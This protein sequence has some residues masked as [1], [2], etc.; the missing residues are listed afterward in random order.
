MPKTEHCGLWM[1]MGAVKTT[2]G[3]NTPNLGGQTIRHI[4]MDGT[5][6]TFLKLDP[7][8]NW[9][10]NDVAV[11]KRDKDFNLTSHE[12]A[13][14]SITRSAVSDTS[15]LTQRKYQILHLSYDKV[16]TPI[17][18]LLTEGFQNGAAAQATFRGPTGLTV[19]PS[20]IFVA[21]ISNNAIRKISRQ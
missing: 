21:D 4:K 10:I 8:L 12:N 17:T 14:I 15:S 9:A 20:G 11:T 16:L 3:G 18:G 13:F 5:V 19:N 1:G 2:P 7:S 6:T